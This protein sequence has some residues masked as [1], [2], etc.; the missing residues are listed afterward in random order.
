MATTFA[1]VGF[2]HPHINDMYNRCSQRGDVQIVAACEEDAGTREALAKAGVVKITHDNFET[3][4]RDVKADVIAIG[5][6]YAKRGPLAIRALEAGLHVIAD[7]PLC[8][9]LAEYEQIERLA[10]QKGR[11]VSLMLDMR[12]SPVFVGFRQLIQAGEIGTIRAISF[13]GQHPL[14]FGSRAGWYF[15]PGKHGG[16]LN[17]IAIH[18]IDSIPWITGKK[19]VELEAARCWHHQPPS[20][21]HFQGCGQM[22][23]KLD[24]EAGV[25]GD[26]SYL[27]PDS[28]G[29]G[30]PYY[31]RFNFWGDGGMIEAGYNSKSITLNKAGEK[32]PRE[33]PLPAGVPGGYLDS[34]LREIKGD[35]SNLQ[36]PSADAMRAAKVSL[37]IQ[38]AA[39]SGACRVKL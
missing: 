36:L 17:D 29:Y 8:T 3:M 2:R 31:W 5:D 38:A 34:F 9:S 15:E 39:D 6:Y 25:M 32:T 35:T 33:I 28:F 18:A 13:G 19:W 10:K 12:D 23:A 16:T 27:S 14:N 24:G 20:A 30:V 4:L 11:V 22:M 26:V 21:P 7:K 37:Q 1:F